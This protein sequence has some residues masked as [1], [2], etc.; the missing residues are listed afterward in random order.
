MNELEKNDNIENCQWC[1]F[2]EKSKRNLRCPI[3]D[4]PVLDQRRKDHK[5]VD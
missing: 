2:S 4:W 1:N 3:H 5:Y